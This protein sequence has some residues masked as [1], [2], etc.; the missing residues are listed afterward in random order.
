MNLPP[1]KQAFTL[2][3]LLVVISIIAVLAAL[4]LPVLSKARSAANSV[5]CVNN[6]HQIRLEYQMF[7]SAH[8]PNDVA[9]FRDTDFGFGLLDADGGLLEAKLQVCPEAKTTSKDPDYATAKTGY[10]SWVRPFGSFGY[11]R[12]GYLVRRIR[13]YEATDVVTV[14]KP[15]LTPLLG[16]GVV[17]GGRPQPTDELPDNFFMPFTGWN[18]NY[19]G[20]M[21][22]WCLERHGKGINMVFVDGHVQRFR[23]RQLW[24]LDW[25]DTFQQERA[26]LLR[27]TNSP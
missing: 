25:Y 1:A 7:L 3:E 4:L 12:N 15:S 26:R 11:A 22:I 20:D 16:D 8:E 2:I 18:Q 10:N 9:F 24:T 5:G 27:Q 14:A 23:P 19:R 6:L 13:E 21:A 17:E